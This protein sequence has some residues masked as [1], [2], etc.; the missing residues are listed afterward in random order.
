MGRVEGGSWEGGE[1]VVVGR[2]ARGGDV[3][4]LDRTLPAVAHVT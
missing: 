1:G 4:V 3:A 2:E